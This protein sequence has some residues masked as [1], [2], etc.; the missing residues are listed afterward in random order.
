[1]LWQGEP[2]GLVFVWFGRDGDG[3]DLFH[4]RVEI[5]LGLMQASPDSDTALVWIAMNW[6]EDLDNPEQAFL[7][8][9]LAA[10]EVERLEDIRHRLVSRARGRRRMLVYLRHRTPASNDRI[11][12]PAGLSAYLHWLD[13]SLLPL[14]APD[15]HLL[16]G[17]SFLVNSPGAFQ[18]SLGDQGIGEV[19][20]FQS[21]RLELLPPFGPLSRHDLDVFMGTEGIDLGVGLTNARRDMLLDEILDRTGGRYEQVA[22]ELAKLPGSSQEASSRTGLS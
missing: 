17:I 3:V 16:A 5:E 9:T 1:M 21:L 20:P 19:R 11:L 13:R 4:G 6:P 7:D 12:D 2:R 14:L 18:A 8:V 15:Q 22:N 10:F